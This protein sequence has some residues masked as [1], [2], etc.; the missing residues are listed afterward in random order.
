MKVLDL[1]RWQ[2]AKTLPVRIQSQAKRVDIYAAPMDAI[3]I[4]KVGHILQSAN[5]KEIV[6]RITA[7]LRDM[8]VPR[9]DVL[10][11]AVMQ[12]IL[13]KLNVKIIVEG[14]RIPAITVRTVHAIT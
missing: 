2:S 8:T 13:I 9:M 12:I 6:I 11:R 4:V 10:T 14:V 3:T 5:V 7:G 1:I